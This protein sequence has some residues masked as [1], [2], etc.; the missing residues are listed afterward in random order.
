VKPLGVTLVTGA[1]MIAAIVAWNPIVLAAALVGA[2]ALLAVSEGPKRVYIS[3]ALFAAVTVLVINPFVSVQGLTVLWQGPSIP[4]LDTQITSEELVYGVGAAIR[5]AGAALAAAAFVRLVD[6]DLLTRAVARVA[7]RSAM[8]TALATRMLP[9]LER[10]ARGLTLAARTRASDLNRRRAATALVPALMG[11]SLERSLG[12]AEAMEA[13]GY[14]EPGAT[15]APERRP[16]AAERSVTV[17]GGLACLTCVAMIVT[18]SAD[19]TYY[20]TVGNPFTPAAIATAVAL[21]VPLISAA[22]VIRWMR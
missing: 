12:L 19:F 13:R 14:G 11:M 2:A 21:V 16:T 10:D 18:G 20:D 6:P 15:R 5:L 4:I 1:A 8:I 7:P 9:A 22:G 3:F 17:L